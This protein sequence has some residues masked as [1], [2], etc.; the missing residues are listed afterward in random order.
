MKIQGSL[1]ETEDQF[2]LFLNGYSI[3]DYD[4]VLKEE[5]DDADGDAPKRSNKI[6]AATF[7][8]NEREVLESAEE[9]SLRALQATIERIVN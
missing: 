3:Y 5:Q 8:I 7:I 1:D 4:R 9:K 2:L 6:S